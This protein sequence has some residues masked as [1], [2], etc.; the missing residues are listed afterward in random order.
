MTS[1]VDVN[2]LLA[3]AATN[4]LI[5][6]DT[7]Q[8]LQIIDIGAQIQAG[9]GFNCDD[10]VAAEVVLVTMLID[11]S[12]SIRKTGG[13]AQAVRDGHNM[14]VDDLLATKQAAQIFV[15]TRYLNGKVLY[16]YIA[17]DQV[18]KMTSKNYDPNG[19]TPLFEQSLV[20]LSTVMAKTQQLDDDAI[21]VRGI[22]VIVTDGEDSTRDRPDLVAKLVADML[23]T[24]NQIVAGM[25]I[26]DGHTDFTAVFRSMGI[27]DNWIHDP[28]RD[29]SPTKGWNLV[30]QSIARFSQG[31]SVGGFGTP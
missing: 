27:P 7:S 20:T 1:T 13:N 12:G 23:A 21:P 8:A 25:G 19:G 15:H 6:Q 29:P 18:P 10:V 5:T 16:P 9:L 24:E 4:G 14:I 22:T 31:G 30:S 28:K 3:G 17:L 26:Y 2:A 11:D